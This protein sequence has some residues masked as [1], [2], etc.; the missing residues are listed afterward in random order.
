MSEL[1][2][3]VQETEIEGDGFQEGPTITRL[4]SLKKKADTLGIKYKS[5]ISE[6]TLAEKINKVLAD[7]ATAKEASDA[8]DDE[9]P[10]A[11]SKTEEAVVVKAQP[12]ED[13]AE[14]RKRSLRMHRVIVRPVDPRRTQLKG[15]IVTAGN[16]SIGV[17]GKYIPF[18]NEAGYHVPEI[19]LNALK[20]RQFTEFYTVTDQHGNEQT[21]SRQRKAFIIETLDPLTEAELAEIRARQ[22]ATLAQE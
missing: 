12:K 8:D 1:N 2:N 22:R 17:T 9:D 20:D 6:A 7:E 18:N 14:Q 3:E 10:E 11:E 4:E 19:L 15:E 21:K 16:G 13:A 5:N